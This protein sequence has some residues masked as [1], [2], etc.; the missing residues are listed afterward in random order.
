MF[1]GRLADPHRKQRA[2]A[3]PSPPPKSFHPD[4]KWTPVFEGTNRLAGL[5]RQPQVALRIR[6][7][8]STTALL[9]VFFGAGLPTDGAPWAITSE[10]RVAEEAL[11]R[12]YEGFSPSAGLRASPE[13]RDV[14]RMFAYSRL[15][16]NRSERSERSFYFVTAARIRSSVTTVTEEH[17]RSQPDPA[18]DGKLPRTGCFH[19]KDS[20]ISLLVQPVPVR[21]DTRL[22][23]QAVRLLCAWSRRRARPFH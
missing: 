1:D 9:P 12:V 17:P 6:Q 21:K 5:L 11:S 22:Y 10:A 3:M 8:G 14:K 16:Q 4:N 13:Y 7:A 20:R 18:C 2:R 19:L 23:L 15:S